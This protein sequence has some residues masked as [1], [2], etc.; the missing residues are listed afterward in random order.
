MVKIS[1]IWLTHL[2]FATSQDIRQGLVRVVSLQNTI[3]ASNMILDT[4][5][6]TQQVNKMISKSFKLQIEA[7]LDNFLY[8][9]MLRLREFQFLA[10]YNKTDRFRAQGCYKCQYKLDYCSHFE[11]KIESLRPS[12]A[13]IRCFDFRD[14]ARDEI[15][16]FRLFRRQNELWQYQGLIVLPSISTFLKRNSVQVEVHTQLPWATPVIINSEF[17]Y[18]KRFFGITKNFFL[19]FLEK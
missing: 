8:F 6:N 18:E 13:E 14:F 4:S 19:D 16:D 15:V 7:K 12:E 3:M 5:Y 1:K 17:N 9:L 2:V 11:K 10:I